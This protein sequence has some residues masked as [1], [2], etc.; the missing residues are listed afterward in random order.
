M[1]MPSRGKLISLMLV[2]IIIPMSLLATFKLA[3]ILP[4]PAEPETVTLETISWEMERPSS[5]T[6]I[7]EMVKSNY[8]DS[9][10]S[11]AT[12]GEILFY[13]ESSMPYF[14]CDGAEL[15]INVSVTRGAATLVSVEYH[16]M[17]ADQFA[18]ISDGSLE[19][20]LLNAKIKEMKQMGANESGAYLRAEIVSHPCLVSSHVFWGFTDGNEAH[21]IEIAFKILYFNGSAYR[22]VILPMQ[23]RMW[24]DAGSDFRNAKQISFGNYTGWF[25]TSSS[26]PWNNDLEDYYKLWI[27]ENT[28]IH[29][30]MTH[31]INRDFNLY[32]YGPDEGLLASSSLPEPNTTEVVTQIIEVSGWR[33]VRVKAVLGVDIYTLE[34]TP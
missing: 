5:I 6:S 13:H 30:Q 31:Q 32:L 25:G 14:G 23:L 11:I 18:Y 17:D 15:D 7:Y 33:Y 27:E 8:S 29:V 22:Q 21:G 20:V 9:A 4:E 12:V 10:I 26:P 3:G 28:T 2:A 34:I 24:P 16:P 1:A 19:L